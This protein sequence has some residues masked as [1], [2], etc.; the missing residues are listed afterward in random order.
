VIWERARESLGLVAPMGL[1]LEYGPMP[2]D[3][4]WCR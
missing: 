4:K 1:N 2:D 3:S